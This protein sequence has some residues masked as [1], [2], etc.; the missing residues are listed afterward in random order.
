MVSNGSRAGK[1]IT[2]LRGLLPSLSSVPLTASTAL[3]P[4]SGRL[5]VLPLVLR[6]QPSAAKGHLNRQ[7]KTGRVAFDEKKPKNGN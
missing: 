2:Q 6:G 7:I 5:E 4:S 1:G 3:V